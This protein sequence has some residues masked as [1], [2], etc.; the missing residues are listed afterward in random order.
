MEPKDTQ[1]KD[2]SLDLLLFK[3]T[4][5]NMVSNILENESNGTINGAGFVLVAPLSPE[6]KVWW[7]L[8]KPFQFNLPL[9]CFPCVQI[10]P[11]TMDFR[12]VLSSFQLKAAEFGGLKL[13]FPNKRP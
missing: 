5:R 6:P 8:F 10:P 3:T 2:T 11:R 13:P 1:K 4:F 9:Q 7:N 12:L